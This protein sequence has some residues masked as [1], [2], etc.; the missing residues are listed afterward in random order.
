MKTLKEQK[1]FVNK[2]HF[3]AFCKNSKNNFYFVFYPFYFN[4]QTFYLDKHHI[5]CKP[6]YALQRFQLTSPAPADKLEYH[7]RC[8]RP[9]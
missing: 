5:K 2:D 9:E 7:F 8:C 4:K 6:G 1:H 3:R